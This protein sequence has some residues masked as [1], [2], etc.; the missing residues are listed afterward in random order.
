MKLRAIVA[1]N[2]RI[3]RKQKGLSQEELADSAGINRNYVG[4]I[5]REEK[6]PTV[7][8]LE[9]LAIALEVNAVDFFVQ[10]GRYTD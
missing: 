3:L 5:E 4:Q 10:R 6:S 8:I 1:R 7:D 9:K 2:L